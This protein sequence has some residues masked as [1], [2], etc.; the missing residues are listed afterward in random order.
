M[1]ITNSTG[2]TIRMDSLRVDWVEFTNQGVRQV[3]LDGVQIFNGSDPNTPSLFP[4]ER[5]WDGSASDRDI[6]P[7][8]VVL[9]IQFEETMVVTGNTVEPT[10]DIGCSVSSSN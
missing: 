10:F 3:I 2:S 4:S 6:G 5:A 7:G 1:T 8:T 9:L